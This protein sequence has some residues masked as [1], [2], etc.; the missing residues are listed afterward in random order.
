MNLEN[1]KEYLQNQNKMLFFHIILLI[2]LVQ[3]N[4]WKTTGPEVEV[5]NTIEN[6]R[7][8]ITQVI[9]PV[10]G[11]PI[12]QKVVGAKVVGGKY[13]GAKY[14]GEKDSGK[15]VSGEKEKWRRSVDETK[16]DVQKRYSPIFVKPVVPVYVK[17]VQP[18]ILKP[19]MPV[20]KPVSPYLA[21]P[22]Y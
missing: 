21:K 18:V 11:E 19:L 4:A 14:S 22:V 3:I 5:T 10:H 2:A 7:H 12:V 13:S 6:G 15:K 1:S 17:P 20:Y 8:V 9:R 16:K